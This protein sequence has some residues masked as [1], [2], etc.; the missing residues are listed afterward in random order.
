MDLK[1]RARQA[2]ASLDDVLQLL[3][4]L[5]LLSRA[6]EDGEISRWTCAAARQL[7][8]A[9]GATF[10]LSEG[11]Y[12]YYAEEEAPEALWRGRRFR[13]QECISGWAIQHRQPAVIP[14]VYID[15]RIPQE[16][17][18]PTFVRSL[19]MMPMGR[20]RSVGSIGI[21]WSREHTATPRELFLLDVLADA[22]ASALEHA[23]CWRERAAPGVPNPGGEAVLTRMLPVLMHDLKNPLGAI[24]L[25]A[26][27]L[28]RRAELAASD[29][30][31]VE[32]ILRSVA[33]AR[34][35]VCEVLEY[36][37]L[38][39]AGGLRLDISTTRMDVLAHT[40]ADEVRTAFPLRQV[41]LLTEEV[42]GRWDAPR[43]A[44]AIINLL[45]N[46]LQY[47]PPNRPVTLRVGVWRG[48][49]CVEVHNE[50][51]CIPEELRPVLFEPF[52]RGHQEGRDSVGLGLFIVD[53]IVRAHGG[54][55]Q[56]RST[57]QDGTTFGLHLPMHQ[58]QPIHPP[59]ESPH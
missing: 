41:D 36:V 43:L 48:E 52:R 21:Y 16:A 1:A 14:D 37:R 51:S 56:L 46:A 45:N 12:V 13:A 55:I 33:R 44:E 26:Q 27:S 24:L 4:A 5:S 42:S 11:E 8:L 28:S 17:Y 10:V 2:G 38:Q 15:P 7:T 57:P 35:L 34:H 31:N 59:G 53:Q 32:R 19:A 9:E 23:E 54:R 58:L 50:G 49:A 47:G 6:R 25:A 40:V 30:K 20:E 39:E 29:L 22:A 3:E 18:R